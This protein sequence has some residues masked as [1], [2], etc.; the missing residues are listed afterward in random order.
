[1][2]WQVRTVRDVWLKIGP[3]LLI[4]FGVGTGATIVAMGGLSTTVLISSTLVIAFGVAILAVLS[5]Y[6]ARRTR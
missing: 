6:I 3:L 1:M 4:G 5:I 2:D